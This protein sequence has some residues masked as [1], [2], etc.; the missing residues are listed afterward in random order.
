MSQ[1]AYTIAK[2]QRDRHGNFEVRFEGSDGAWIGVYTPSGLLGMTVWAPGAHVPTLDPTELARL[3]EGH[4]I[5]SDSLLGP[6]PFRRTK[7]ARSCR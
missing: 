5:K 6:G 2:V 7:K 1:P 3:A 4:E